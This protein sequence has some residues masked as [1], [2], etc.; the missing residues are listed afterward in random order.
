MTCIEDREL[1]DSRP[2]GTHSRFT[3]S[4]T[5]K[6]VLNEATEPIRRLLN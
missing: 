1:R 2:K 4:H 5:V 3:R 6:G